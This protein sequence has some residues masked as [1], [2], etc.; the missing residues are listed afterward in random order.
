MSDLGTTMRAILLLIIALL[1]AQSPMT[2]EAGTKLEIT[3]IKALLFEDGT[4]QFSKDVLSN[5][6][7][8]IPELWNITMWSHSM[9]VVVEISGPPG[10]IAA[11]GSRVNFVATY[12]AWTPG[13]NAAPATDKTVR[14]AGSITNFSDKGKSYVG[15]WLYDTGC[16]PVQISAT[17]SADPKSKREVAV[18]FACGD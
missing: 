11:D 14:Q 10:K 12:K 7:P 6:D 17:L 15:F 13:L 16:Y 4:G 18:P 1:F 3:A 9:L 8:D 5:S 2:A